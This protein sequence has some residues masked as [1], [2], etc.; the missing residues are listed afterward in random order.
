L[1]FL[2]G[3]LDFFFFSP[4]SGSPLP[5]QLCG[6]IGS[7]RSFRTPEG[8]KPS[9]RKFGTKRP[10]HNR[11][12]RLLRLHTNITIFFELYEYKSSHVHMIVVW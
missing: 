11:K 7:R 9:D 4:K 3:A 5:E 6:K 8:G 2:H 10:R 1:L 12:R